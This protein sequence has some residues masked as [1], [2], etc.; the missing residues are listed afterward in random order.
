MTANAPPAPRFPG[1]E[2]EI[3][4]L[5]GTGGMAVV[6]RARDRQHG[7]TVA[8]KVLRPEVA[9]VVGAERFQREITVASGLSH[10]NILPLL[11]SGEA[12]VGDGRTLPYYVMPLIEGESLEQRIRREQRLP[13]PDA[14]RIT[15]EILDALE[16]AHA[17]GVVHRD[18][19]PANVLLSATHAVVA[20]FGLA[21][22]LPTEELISDGQSS[23][24]ASGF[25]VGTPAYM[26]PEQALGERHVDGRTDVFALGCV[27]YEMLTGTT[28][29]DAPTAQSIIS[30][31][32]NG[33]FVPVGV[34][35]HG[36]PARI[37]EVLRRALSP[38][39]SDRF[40]NAAEFRRAID[41]V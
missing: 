30:R 12:D 38:E 7:R 39:R 33:M 27:L 37:D 17:R 6:Y 32:M 35:R 24:T 40:A 3:D 9:H 36:V 11:G 28:P 20:D 2:Y 18:I 10:P 5:L 26:S 19:K 16:Y 14:L 4:G 34:M 22:L 31:K 21:R 41:D 23:I 25:A 15:R 8:I 1:G 29:F 13:L